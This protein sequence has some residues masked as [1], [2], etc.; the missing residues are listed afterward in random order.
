MTAPSLAPQRAVGDGRGRRRPST[1]RNRAIGAI[2]GVA[3]TLLAVGALVLGS[4]GSSAE[5]PIEAGG[6]GP[7]VAALEGYLAELEPIA[8]D[9]G[10]VV[11]LGLKAG[12]TDIGRSRY[13]DD[14]LI[15]MAEGW[16]VELGTLREELAAVTPPEGLAEAHLVFVAAFDGYLETADTLAAAAHGPEADRGELAR[17][18]A[19][20]GR[21]ADDLWDEGAALVQ[22]GA[23][24]SG[25][26]SIPWLPT[27]E[28][29]DR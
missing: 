9:A 5:A 1:W 14:V 16:A 20:Q 11:Q 3:V 24:R 17:Q 23:T 10:R 7:S 28:G 18:A 25:E 22:A 27:P 6:T 15:G 2:G 29:G 13:G 4:V 8:K 26:P 21:A 19:A 12:I